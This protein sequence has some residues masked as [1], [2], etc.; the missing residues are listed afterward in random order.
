MCAVHKKYWLVL[1]LTLVVGCTSFPSPENQFQAQLTKAGQGSSQAQ[2]SVGV[3]YKN[4]RGVPVDIR[5]SCY[6]FEK[7]ANQNDALAQLEVSRCYEMSDGLGV[8]L[9][10]ARKWLLVSASN[11]IN[12][13]Q[14][15]EQIRNNLGGEYRKLDLI[16]LIPFA[17]NGIADKSDLNRTIVV[18][19]SNLFYSK[20]FNTYDANGVSLWVEAIQYSKSNGV[21]LNQSLEII[22]KEKSAKIAES[23]RRLA[24]EKRD[25]EQ[26]E[27]AQ[28]T[29][30]KRLAKESEEK[31]ANYPFEAVLTCGFIGQHVNAT[32]CFIGEHTRTQLELRN[33]EEY[34]MYQG[35]E[36]QK[37][38]GQEFKDGLHLSLHKNFSITAQNASNNLILNLKIIDKKTNRLVYEKSAAKYGV[39]SVRN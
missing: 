30:A 22:N 15:L 27:L 9:D 33:G 26:K 19:K 17:K 3:M 18:M 24:S 37:A 29:A 31:A 36:L 35:W 11:S 12:P 25:Q 13:A 23:E 5:K 34:G 39:V 2:Y 20:N 28:V 10:E 16:E 4:G 38:G 1:I 14:A 7:A 32:A 8:N 6:W 21:T